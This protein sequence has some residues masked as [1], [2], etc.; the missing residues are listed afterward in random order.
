MPGAAGSQGAWTLATDGLAGA[1]LSPTPRSSRVTRSA[2][3]SLPPHRAAGRARGGHLRRLPG[4]SDDYALAETVVGLYKTE[5]IRRRGPWRTA[6][7]RASK[8]RSGLQLD[9]QMI[10]DRFDDPRAE[11]L[12]AKFPHHAIDASL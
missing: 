1:M 9:S 2:G 3:A 8:A 7:G 10:D 6:A 4:D 12:I 11:A 5:L